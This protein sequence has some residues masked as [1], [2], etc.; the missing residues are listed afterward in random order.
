MPAPNKAR[1][2]L[3]AVPPGEE[4]LLDALERWAAVDDRRGRPARGLGLDQGARPP[5]ADLPR[6]RRRRRR[7]GA[8]QGPRGAQGAAA[9]D[10]STQALAAVADDSGLGAT[11]QTDVD[12]RRPS[13]RDPRRRRA[14]H[15]VRGLPGLVD[16]G[17]DGRAAGVRLGGRGRTARHRLGVRRLLLLDAARRR[18]TRLG[19]ARQRPASS[20]SPARRTPRSP[21][22]ST[23]CRAAVV[24]DVVDAHPPVRDAGGVRRAGGGRR[25]TPWTSAP[26]RSCCRRAAGARRLA[27]DR[28]GAQRPRRAGH[29]AGAAG[30]ARAARPAG[31]PRLRRRGRGRPAA[32]LPDVPRG[33]PAPPRAARR[34][35]SPATGS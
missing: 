27:R 17:D 26:A 2:F 18:S 23:T 8:R 3:A 35:R 12:L 1:E 33:D 30:H 16:E 25:A 32:P 28:P 22:C 24:A 14:G 21:S 13:S 34:R 20:G 15:E 11:G 5:A 7:A 10:S 4:P 6:R 31:A 29:A 9:A 19:G